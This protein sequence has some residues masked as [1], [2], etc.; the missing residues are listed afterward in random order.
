M[1]ARDILVSMTGGYR[2]RRSRMRI[3]VSSTPASG[4]PDQRLGF[5]CMGSELGCM[6]HNNLGGNGGQSVLDQTGDTPEEI[7]NLALF[8]NIQPDMYWFG[9][10]CAPE[11]SIIA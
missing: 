1:A 3:V 9:A 7:A 8:T 5:D 2:L 10:E 6:F 4:F 11:S